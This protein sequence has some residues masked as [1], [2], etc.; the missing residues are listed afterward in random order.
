MNGTARFFAGAFFACSISALSAVAGEPVRTNAFA[1]GELWPDD[2]GTHINAHGGGILQYEG[3]WYW[4]GEHKVAG[5]GGNNAQVGVHV[6]SSRDLYN[7]QDEG[8]ALAVSTNADSPIHKGCILER[9]KVIFNA[10][11]KKFVMWFHLELRNAEHPG[12]SAA[13]AG[14]ATADQPAGPYTFLHAGRLNAKT[15][16]LART[17]DGKILHPAHN[18]LDDA[19]TF[20]RDFEPG[21]MARDCTLFVD[22][23]GKAY[24]IASS[25]ENRYLHFNQLT[26]D[27]TEANGS[28]ARFQADDFRAN[29]E[30]PALFRKDGKYYLMTSGTTGWNPNPGRSFTADSIWGPWHYLGNPCRGDDAQNQTTFESQSTFF[31]PAPGTTDNFIYLGDRWRPR[32]PVDGRYIWLPVEWE[33]GKPGLRWHEQWDLSVFGVKAP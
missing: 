17:A 25:E 31:L 18:E 7:W 6:Y 10:K 20:N 15:L 32:N 13:F 30:A 22:A 4:F 28:F 21:Q 29:N 14:V 5:P 3:V 11:T 19:K 1:P 27:F 26:D 8:I 23:D 12:Y 24:F 9:P 16:P 33:A 2:Q